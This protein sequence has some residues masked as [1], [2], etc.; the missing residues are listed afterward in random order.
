MIGPADGE[1]ET[2]DAAAAAAGAGGGAAAAPVRLFVAAV[3]PDHVRTLVTGARAP[4]HE[5]APE[6]TWTRPS[7]WH[8]TLAYLGDV[9][10]DRV[11]D[12][13]AVVTEATAEVAPIDLHLA[14]PGRPDH[15]VLWIELADDPAGALADLGERV[16]TAVAAAGLPV[17]H[18]TV[19]PHLTLARAARGRAVDDAVVRA[20][21]PVTATF[22]VDHLVVL[23][24]H[25]GDGPARYEPVAAAPLLGAARS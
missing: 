24:S 8:V 5:L 23:R 4:A 16:Q 12:V 6:L 20:V 18:R 10:A 7:G 13:G 25:L 14:A 21:A 19:R 2:R 9:A 15:R 3:P 17:H 11:L 22:T 1:G